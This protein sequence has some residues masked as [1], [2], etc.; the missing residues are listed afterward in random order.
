MRFCKR[1]CGGLDKQTEAET[2]LFNVSF[3]E[4]YLRIMV[5]FLNLTDLF[6]RVFF[7]NRFRI[8]TRWKFVDMVV[9]SQRCMTSVTAIVGCMFVTT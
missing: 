7:L 1:G 6:D 3:N 8:P 9:K 2:I 5:S 4:R